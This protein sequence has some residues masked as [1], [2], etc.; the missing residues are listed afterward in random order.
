MTAGALLLLFNAGLLPWEYKKIIFSWQM[1]LA[2]M[3]FL[4]LFSR[5]GW[6]AGIVLILI[7]GFFILPKFNIEGLEFITQNVWALVF[8]VV[9][10]FIIC[11]AVRRRNYFQ[12]GVF[13]GDS[14]KK[15]KWKNHKNDSGHI[16]ST[17]VFSDAKEK[18]D[19]NNFKGG[20]IN[21][22]FGGIEIDLSEAQLAEGANNLILNAVFGGVILYVP[23]DWNIEIQKSQAFGSFEDNRPNRSFNEIDDNRKLIITANV[24][25]GNGEIKCKLV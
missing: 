16:E 9:G 6:I 23:A 20:E 22:V 7:G 5:N 3:G 8:M 24:V 15:G 14:S 13:V 19:M 2:A 4:L 17:C 18:W 12:F 1:L 25:F 11:G 21:S 10:V